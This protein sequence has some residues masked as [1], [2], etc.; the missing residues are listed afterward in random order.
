MQ[1]KPT[2]AN[3]IY[4]AFVLKIDDPRTP[5]RIHPIETVLF[6]LLVGILC[7]ANDLV[8]AEIRAKKKQRFIERYVDCSAGIPTHDTMGRV[9]A[10]IDPEQFLEA[11]AFF[12]SRMTGRVK[13]EIINV[14]G[15]TLRGALIKTKRKGNAQVHIV[16]V[17]SGLRGYVLAQM[18][19][20]A[21]AN[22]VEAARDLL[23][24]LVVNGCIVTMDAAHTSAETLAM[25]A[26][27][28]AHVVVGLKA[29]NKRLLT[30]AKAAFKRQD[31]VV[32]DET[33]QG[34]GR[35]DH[36]RY[37]LV[38]VGEG[39]RAR[40][41]S[42]NVFIRTARVRYVP[43][44][45]TTRPVFTY[46]ATSIEL[47][48]TERITKA[49]RERWFIEN[50]LHHV[51][52]VSF[53]EDNVRLR[54]DDAAENFSRMLHLA[55][56]VLKADTAARMSMDNKRACANADDQDLERLIAA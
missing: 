52:D 46:Y 44:G 28:G 18:R 1:R 22:E 39:V 14:D 16:N 37:A 20:K 53:R 7:G 24:L 48:Q 43:R 30:D 34:H 11:F 38:D 4:V 10:M 51:L 42:L 25:I 33:E 55:F 17:F 3:S 36:R 9:L 2:L 15:K 12:M 8:A 26:E 13:D 32:V 49:V 27:R 40:Y 31:A 19:S 45:R 23:R 5:N 29:N 47:S 50:K 35:V 21:A 54:T 41:P 6:S 56:N